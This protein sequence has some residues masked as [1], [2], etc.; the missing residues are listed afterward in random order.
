VDAPRA[1]AESGQAVV[2]VHERE[3]RKGLHWVPP[4]EGHWQFQKGGNGRAELG[5]S[6]SNWSTRGPVKHRMQPAV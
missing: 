1:G 5:F 3:Q 4:L 6:R 2:E